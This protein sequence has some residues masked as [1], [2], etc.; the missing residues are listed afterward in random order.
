MGNPYQVLLPTDEALEDIA[1]LGYRIEAVHQA[2]RYPSPNEL[3]TVL[4]ALENCTVHYSV[5]TNSWVADVAVIDEITPSDSH[6]MVVGYRGDENAPHKFFFEK[7]ATDLNLHIL[8]RIT[9]ICGPLVLV[10]QIGRPLLVTPDAPE[11]A[12]VPQT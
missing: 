8:Y 6:V 7:G 9:K 12:L 4:D 5:S 1:K 2:S 11:D 10:P 3:R